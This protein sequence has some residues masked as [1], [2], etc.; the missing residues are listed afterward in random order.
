MVV[1]LY[2]TILDLPRLEIRKVIMQPKSWRAVVYFQHP[3]I[4]DRVAFSTSITFQIKDRD[5]WYTS[6]AI[7]STEDVAVG[8]E[9]ASRLK[10][11][12]TS[13]FAPY[14]SAVWLGENPW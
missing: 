1:S 14:F 2:V 12:L 6:F 9:A 4:A 8:E 11:Q 10:E 3:R 13:I 5:K 7:N